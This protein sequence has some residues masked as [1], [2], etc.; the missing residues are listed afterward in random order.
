[1]ANKILVIGEEFMKRVFVGLGEIPS[2]FAHEVILDFEAQLNLAE[3]DIKKYVELI[4]EHLMPHKAKVALEDAKA[5]AA[6]AEK[7]VST[8]ETAAKEVVADGPVA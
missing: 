1:M 8:V 5:A 3:Q 6:V 4:E 2:K 7:V